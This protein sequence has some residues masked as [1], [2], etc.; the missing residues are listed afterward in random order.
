MR[1]FFKTAFKQIHAP[2]LEAAVKLLDGMDAKA[3]LSK[4][5]GHLE[6]PT[7]QKP[8]KNETDVAKGGG[9]GG[10][11][12]RR[13]KTGGDENTPAAP[14]SKETLVKICLYFACVSRTSL[15]KS[16]T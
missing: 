8:P 11:G 12:E 15:I 6:R 7:Y 1:M 5:S 4:P 14:K 16:S 2:T 13:K 10:K 3:A 9:R